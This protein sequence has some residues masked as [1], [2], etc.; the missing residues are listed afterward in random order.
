MVA[1]EALIRAGR[2]CR[3]SLP[4]LIPALVLH[5]DSSKRKPFNRLEDIMP[6]TEDAVVRESDEESSKA[7]SEISAAISRGEGSGD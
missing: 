7:S 4:H 1:R 3:S 5:M 2:K 6:T